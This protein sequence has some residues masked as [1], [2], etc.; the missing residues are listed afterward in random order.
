MINKK[1]SLV[2]LFLF[3]LISTYLSYTTFAKG[4]SL[5]LPKTNYKA[6]QANQNSQVTNDS[7]ASEEKTE[8]CPLN[9]ELFGKTVAQKW[10]KKRP[11]G[12]MVENST[13]ARPQ[14]GLS[15]AD[16]VYEAVAE[17]GITRFLN[18]YYCQDASYVGPVRSARIYFVK[19]LQE[20]GDNPLYAHV[21]GANTDGPADALGEID[22]LGW[23]LYNDLNQF[24]VPFPYY[25]RDYERLPGRITE[26]TVYTTTTKLW[27][28]A[29]SKRNLT[30]T[31]KKGKA[32][33]VNFEKWKFKDDT[34]SAERGKLTKISFSF[35]DSF[36]KDYSVV[37]TYEKA[38]NS[39]KRSNGGSPHIDKN[40]D[41]QLESKNVVVVFAKESPANDG[42][43]GGHILYKLTG[44]GDGLVFL[45]GNAIEITWNKKTEDSRMKFFD[46]N[47]R[48][49]SFVRGQIWIEILP[50][51]NEVTY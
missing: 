22:D 26:H 16:I 14:S 32:W 20:Y 27:E 19:L 2:T 7:I 35:W 15:S 17:G 39:F 48:E 44:S 25:W 43:P 4:G 21:G 6:P 38:I 5:I 12:I 30:N 8:E 36:A 1:L 28:F 10:A 37:W 51:G 31:D 9:G 11:L 13:A 42:Y 46:T 40:T 33:D 47:G 34:N 29:K 18:I 49:V 50:V 45:D 24:G 23:G 41:K 3:F